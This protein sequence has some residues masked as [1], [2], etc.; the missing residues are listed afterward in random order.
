MS[1]T[2]PWTAGRW[3]A[4]GSCSLCAA[5]VV[6]DGFRDRAAYRDFHIT[7]LCQAC[8]DELYLRP[9]VADARMRY[10]VRRGVL[11]APAVRDGAVVELALLPFLC[12]VP[13]ARVAWE[14]RWMLRAGAGLAPLDPWRELEPAEPVLR[15]HQIRLTEVGDLGGTE[16]CAALDV[17]FAIV[18]DAPARDALAGLP[19]KDSALCV[20]L[21]DGLRSRARLGPPLDGLLAYWLREPVS[22]VRACALLVL[23]LADP[24]GRGRTRLGTLGP[25]LHPHPTRFPE[26]DLPL[27]GEDR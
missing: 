18:L 19:L 27:P 22:V 7:G 8:Q 6:P 15:S 13:E 20:A 2:I 10:P 5:P 25:L 16:V 4:S 26:L 23:A 21:A 12:I 24:T 17:D 11:A 9:S 14:A 3:A 1:P